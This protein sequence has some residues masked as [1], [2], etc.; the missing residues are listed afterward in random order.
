MFVVIPHP[1]KMYWKNTDLH[2]LLILSKFLMSTFLPCLGAPLCASLFLFVG[3]LV[4]IR[5]VLPFRAQMCIL[6]QIYTIP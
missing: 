2:L 5:L 1:I 4:P 6:A 3:I